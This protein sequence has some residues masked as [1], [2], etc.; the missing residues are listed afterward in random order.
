ML[1][2]PCTNAI[3]LGARG[4]GQSLDDHFGLGAEVYGVY[5]GL[6]KA[7]TPKGLTTSFLPVR[8]PAVPMEYWLGGDPNILDSVDQARTETRVWVAAIHTKCPTT[9][10]VLAG[11]SQDAWASTRLRTISGMSTQVAV[12][13]CSDFQ[14]QGVAASPAGLLPL[15]T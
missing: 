9:R 15:T 7:L 13:G 12:V 2:R 4:S 14:N 8:Y 11:Y 5:E 3:V 10:I 6:A 1:D